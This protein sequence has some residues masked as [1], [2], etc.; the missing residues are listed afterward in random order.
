MGC[1]GLDHHNRVPLGLAVRA[2]VKAS[3]KGFGEVRHLR[4]HIPSVDAV[5]IDL[6]MALVVGKATAVASMLASG[7]RATDAYLGTLVDGDDPGAYEEPGAIMW[8][9]DCGWQGASHGFWDSGDVDRLMYRDGHV[10]L[11]RHH[12]AE[13][14]LSVLDGMEEVELLREMG[15][16]DEAFAARKSD[17]GGAPDGPDG[18]SAAAPASTLETTVTRTGVIRRMPSSASASSGSTRAR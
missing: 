17:A 14:A 8:I 2:L 10:I 12:L 4:G 15:E 11:V 16:E 5:D 6:L 18:R 1:I 3:G 9:A 7:D 13:R